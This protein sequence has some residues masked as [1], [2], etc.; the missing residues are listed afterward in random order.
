ME[1]KIVPLNPVPDHPKY[2]RLPSLSRSLVHSIL[3][4]ACQAMHT[5]PIIF[6][7]SLKS[8]SPE[9][10]TKFS[11]RVRMPSKALV[12][13][14]EKPVHIR[15]NSPSYIYKKM[16]LN[17][18]ENHSV[19][20][21]YYKSNKASRQSFESKTNY[22]C[23][24]GTI[25]LRESLTPYPEKPLRST[26]GNFKKGTFSPQGSCIKRYYKSS[27]ESRRTLMKNISEARPSQE[28]SEE[29]LSPYYTTKVLG[30]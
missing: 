26:L 18:E 11:T 20:H 17:K 7:I 19:K 28:S 4:K 29:N 25:N 5:K 23:E 22:F 27:E 1:P 24:I 21:K 14:K 12:R 6:S 9:G 16:F 8:S 30:N 3:P 2:L 13:P 15:P 10:P